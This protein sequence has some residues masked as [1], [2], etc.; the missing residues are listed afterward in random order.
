MSGA[1]AERL[2]TYTDLAERWGVG[3]RQARRLADRL[4]VPRLRMGHRTVRFRPQAVMD[5]E[6]RASGELQRRRA[7]VWGGKEG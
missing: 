2:W 3:D 7:A 5:A 4:K 6:A 1:N